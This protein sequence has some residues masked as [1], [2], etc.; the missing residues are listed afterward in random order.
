MSLQTVSTGVS[1]QC[2]RSGKTSFARST[3]FLTT[4]VSVVLSEVPVSVR[5]ARPLRKASGRYTGGVCVSLFYVIDT[6]SIR[7]RARIQGEP[8]LGL[9]IYPSPLAQTLAMPIYPYPY[10]VPQSASGLW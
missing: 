2:P 4:S 10:W 5:G 7:T 6:G 8:N 3:P 1:L 9:P